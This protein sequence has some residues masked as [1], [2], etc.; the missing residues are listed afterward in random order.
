MTWK[1][2]MGK[3][4]EPIIT[5]NNEEDDFTRISFKPDLVKFGMEALDRDI[6]ALM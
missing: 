5:Y 6:I 3:K 2:N 1:D 4:G